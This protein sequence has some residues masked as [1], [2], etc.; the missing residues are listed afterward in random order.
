M[1]LARRKQTDTTCFHLPEAS[2]GVRLIE[3][4]VGARGWELVLNGEASVWEDKK[5]L[6]VVVGLFH[7][8][9]GV[10]NAPELHPERWWI[11]R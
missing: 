10:L 9:L 5:L 1:R 6:E 11:S 2:R 3:T 7:N 4:E 8:G